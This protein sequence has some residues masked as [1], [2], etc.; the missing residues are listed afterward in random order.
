[1]MHSIYGVGLK[2]H[3]FTQGRARWVFVLSL[4]NALARFPS[5]SDRRVMLKIDAEG[6]EPRVM[7][8]AKTLL[9]MAGSL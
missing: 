3:G 4:D 1:M 5:A 6:F 7:A 2:R 8:G 9:Q